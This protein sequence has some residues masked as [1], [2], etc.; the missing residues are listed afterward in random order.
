MSF[1]RSF[2]L[3]RQSILKRQKEIEKVLKE[4]K[5]ISGDVFN[6]Y[7]LKSR[8]AKVGFLVNKRVGKAVD[9]NKMKRLMREAYRL[10]KEKFE[11]VWVIFY[12][13]K[14]CPDFHR[15]VKEIQK[16]N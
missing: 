6:V 15:L 11:A 9:R 1:K 10:N 7:L 2:N 16:I 12:I 8:E 14:H 3:P 5:R 13:K 4:G